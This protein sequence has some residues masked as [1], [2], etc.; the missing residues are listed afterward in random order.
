MGEIIR[1]L[2]ADDHPLVRA[3]IRTTLTAEPNLSVV[4]E[5]TD[6]YEAQRLCQSLNPDVLLLDLNMPGPSPAETVAYIREHSPSVHV[7]VLTAYDDDAYVR[8]MV[9]A[10]AMGYVLKDE[11]PKTLVRAI[12]AVMQ[13]NCWFSQPLMQKLA[14]DKDR[15]LVSGVPQSLTSRELEVLRFVVAGKTNQEIAVMLGISVKT[16]EKHLGELFTKLGVS[17]RVEAAVYAVRSG[18]G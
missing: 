7:I 6:G 14:H 12:H 5:A 13:G 1:V 8:G 9:A 10:G 11:A 3:G 18:L 2:L 17:S 16:V 15:T 4:G